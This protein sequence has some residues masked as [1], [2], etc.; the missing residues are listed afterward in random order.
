MYGLECTRMHL[1]KPKFPVVGGGRGIPPDTPTVQ[2]HSSTCTYSAC[3]LKG[4]GPNCTQSER[5]VGGHV[6]Q[7]SI[8]G[9]IHWY[10]ISQECIQ[11]LQKNFCFFV[12]QIG[13][14]LTTPLPV[15]SHAPHANQRDDT[16]QQSKEET[17]CN[18]GLVFLFCGSLRNYESIKTGEK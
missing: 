7:C 17:L 12:N 4:L 5:L 1:R 3:P 14:A 16:E 18:N 15:D 6:L 11:T 10:K 2:V 9:S 8:A 13:N